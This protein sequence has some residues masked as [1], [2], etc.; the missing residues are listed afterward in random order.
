M[1]SSCV[2]AE[3]VVESERRRLAS[4]LQDEVVE[5][6]NLLFVEEPC[7]PENV[8]A[9]ARISERSTTPIARTRARHG[10]M[11]PGSR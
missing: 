9:M 4:L 3:P 2:L 5:P 8:K 7:P 11:A 1:L 6:L 10:S